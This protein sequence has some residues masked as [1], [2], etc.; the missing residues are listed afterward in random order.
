MKFKSYLSL[1]AIAVLIASCGSKNTEAETE[2]GTPME[3]MVLTDTTATI[4]IDSLGQDAEGIPANAAVEEMT[5]EE[6]TETAAGTAAATA[7]DQKAVK[8][9]L[10]KY[11]SL[12]DQI[13]KLLARIKKGDTSAIA[14]YQKLVAEAEN[15]KTI[16]DGATGLSA[17][18]MKTLSGLDKTLSTVSTAYDA[19]K[20]SSAVEK[21]KEVV[22]KGVEKGKE[23]V[24]KGVEKGKEAV[25]KGVE[26]GK[27]AVEKG[28]E[29]GKEAIKGILN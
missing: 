18:E 2:E 24:E 7:T 25:E 14:E 20:G 3:E 23:A 6:V 1:A 17:A 28:V 29:K 13:N 22:E 8:E 19:V 15:Y 12:V 10:S 5:V 16:L 26:K 4:G 27:E 9:A 11:Q 21:G